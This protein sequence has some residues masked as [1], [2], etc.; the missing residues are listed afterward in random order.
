MI[1]N[2]A[3]FAGS[4]GQLQDPRANYTVSAGLVF[5]YPFAQHAA[6][7]ALNAAREATIKARLSEADILMQVDQAVAHGVAAARAAHAQ[8]AVLVRTTEVAARDL[9]VERRA[10]KAGGPPA[11]TCSRRQDSLAGV[12]SALMRAHVDELKALAVV[13]AA[14]GEILG[15]LAGTLQ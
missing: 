2:G 5:R 10:S 15:R 12:Q 7:G 13:D 6:R 8:V 14:T 11:S 1:G 9:E 3:D 4:Y